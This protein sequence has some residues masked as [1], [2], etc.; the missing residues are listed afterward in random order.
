[1]QKLAV[2]LETKLLISA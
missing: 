1:M 2:L